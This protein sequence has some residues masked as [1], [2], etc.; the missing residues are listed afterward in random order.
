MERFGSCL[1]LVSGLGLTQSIRAGVLSC[2]YHQGSPGKGSGVLAEVLISEGW[3]SPSPL[4]VLR[5]GAASHNQRHTHHAHLRGI[6]DI[7]VFSL[8]PGH[9]VEEQKRPLALGSILPKHIYPITYNS[10]RYIRG[11]LHTSV[12]PL[13]PASATR[14]PSSGLCASPPSSSFAWGTQP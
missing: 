7:R 12:Q 5:D 11:G 3:F 9:T 14:S 13:T 4:V 8:P 2:Q 1:F 10:T 6:S